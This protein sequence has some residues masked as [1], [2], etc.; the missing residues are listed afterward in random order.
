MTAA[1]ARSRASAS[2]SGRAQARLAFAEL[3]IPIVKGWS[4]EVAQQVAYLGVQVHGGVGYIEETGAAQYAR[5]AR[6]T[7]IYEGTT[8]IQANDLIGRKIVRDEG[9]ALACRDRGGA[10]GRTRAR[11]CRR[12]SARGHRQAAARGRRRA[13]RRG[14]FRGDVAIGRI[15]EAL[16][17]VPS[18]CSSW[19]ASSSAERSSD[20]P[21]SSP[22][23]SLS[24]GDGD[25]NFLRAKIVTARHFARSLP[26][27]SCRVC[28][29]RSW[30]ARR[31][32]SRSATT[33]SDANRTEE[34]T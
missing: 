10:R 22:R 5:D 16:R 34:S 14:T 26:D 29:R 32:F 27:P 6:I 28:T 9:Q 18:R 25:A 33:S 20:A 30:P 8:G 31:A 3:M 23:R 1:G 4:T 12:R 15:R 11:G 2:R 17:P 24:A 7:T 21:R 19:P 13:G